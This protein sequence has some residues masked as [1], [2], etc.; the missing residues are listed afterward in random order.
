[1]PTIVPAAP[2]VDPSA[3]RATP[4]SPTLMRPSRESRLD[5]AVHDALLMGARQ[6]PAQLP[7]DRARLPGRH[8]PP[9]QAAREILAVDELGDV[10][11]ALGGMPHVV[12]LDDA[13]IRDAGKQLRLARERLNPLGVLGPPRLDHLDGDRA[14]QPAVAPLI[15]APE[16]PLPDRGVKLVTVVQRAAGQVGG[17]WHAR[18]AYHRRSGDRWPAYATGMSGSSTTSD[19]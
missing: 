17:V 7:G 12:D 11:Q 8:R 6:G 5:V 15:D 9:L 10:V 16:R 19:Q 2:S 13:R 18:R 4:K 3:S 1:V 14:L